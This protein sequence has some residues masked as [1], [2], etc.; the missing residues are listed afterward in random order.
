MKVT[1]SNLYLCTIYDEKNP[2]QVVP[3]N[4]IGKD[5]EEAIKLLQESNP[6]ASIASVVCCQDLIDTLAALDD[7]IK[8]DISGALFKGDWEVNP[9]GLFGTSTD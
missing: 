5:K 7:L 9:D 3:L 8:T 6:D 4:V 2:L 1:P